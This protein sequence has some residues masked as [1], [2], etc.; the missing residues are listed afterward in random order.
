MTRDEAKDKLLDAGVVGPMK[1]ADFLDG[2]VALG[3]LKLDEPMDSITR[4]ALGLG[5]PE[6]GRSEGELRQAL[7]ANGLRIV[8]K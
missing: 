8:E 6:G 1:A 4:L 3:I 7:E 2:L 5:W